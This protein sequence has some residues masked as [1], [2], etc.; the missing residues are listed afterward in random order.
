[1]S[2]ALTLP[3]LPAAANRP[4][5]LM[6]FSDQHN[7][8]MAGFMGSKTVR[9]P[10]LDRFAAQGTTF[11]NAY[12]N[13]PLCSPSRQSFMAGLYAHQIGCYD[14]TTAMPEDTVT[15]A[16]ML[17]LAGYETSLVGKMHFNGYQKMYG[18]DR[19]PVLE[20]SNSGESFHAW[21]VRASCDWTR[22][23]PIYKPI[24]EDVQAAGADSAKR[25]P[26]FQKDL[27]VLKGTL[28]MIREKGRAAKQPK[29]GA[30]KKRTG[31]ATP[32]QPWAICSSF[33]LPHPPFKARADLL[34]TYRGLGDLP[35]NRSGEGRDTCDRALQQYT[36]DLGSLTDAQIKNA[37]ETYF[38]LI[39][40]F[41]EYAGQILDT[42]EA[43]G[44]AEN[45]VVFYFSDHGEMAG[46]H[47][48]WSKLTLLESSVRVPLVVRW[49]GKTVAGTRVDTPV[50]LVD[51]FP[52]FIDIAGIPLPPP[53]TLPGR[54]LVPL[55]PGAGGSRAADALAGRF[56]FGEFEGEGWPHPRCFARRGRYK[57]I[58]NHVPQVGELR[59]YD[60]EKDPLEMHN[61]AGQ[62]G[63]AHVE[64]SFRNF[65]STFWD[66]RKIEA[67]VIASQ[68]RRKIARNQNVCKDAG[69]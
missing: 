9:T 34:K 27:E 45:T 61:L 24:A 46:E 8:N 42:L 20:G 25:E 13:A 17:S 64:Q 26:I 63:V 36:G 53:L 35:A 16:H 3:Q 51:L 43:S 21:G 11:T 47:G 10:N 38:A 4:N 39:T 62:T 12:C 19:R 50:S 66:P 1:M 56:V 57:F 28:K 2:D 31:A 55:F 49:P 32:P 15:W 30:G 67:D 33:V 44:L 48:L 14:N 65:L 68:T 41:D 69:W 58:Y 22:P 37:R 6:I 59:L 60:L 54:S 5:I 52:T 40:E 7:A 18:F 29:A 23:I